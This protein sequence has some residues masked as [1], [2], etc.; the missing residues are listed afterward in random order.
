MRHSKSGRP[1]RVRYTV[2]VTESVDTKLAEI[3]TQRD[4]SKAELVRAAA[5]LFA[6]WD[7]ME[8]RGFTVGGWKDGPEGSRETEKLL[9]PV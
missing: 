3:A 7:S 2:E 6:E 9:L 4:T 1:R 5:R 8:R